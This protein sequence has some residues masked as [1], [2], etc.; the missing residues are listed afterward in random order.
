MPSSIK[1]MLSGAAGAVIAVGRSFLLA[2]LLV[3]RFLKGF[4][5]MQDKPVWLLIVPHDWLEAVD[6]HMACGLP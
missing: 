1:V 5:A 3:K 4:V 6:L 2:S